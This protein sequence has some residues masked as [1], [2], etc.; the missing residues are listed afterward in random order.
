MDLW[1]TKESERSVAGV[2]AAFAFLLPWDITYIGDIA[3][4]SLVYFRFP[5]WEFQWSPGIQ[6]VEETTFRF[7]NEAWDLRRGA[8]LEPAY[9][10]YLV[11]AAF[12]VLGVLLAIGLFVSEPRE[13]GINPTRVVGGLLAFAGLSFLIGWWFLVTRGASGI[14]IPL[15]AT[16]TTA[17]GVVLVLAD[18]QD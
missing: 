11:G 10:A 16:L 7:L 1:I 5:L 13:G 9:D 8:P 6:G 3:G 12:I 14:D 18:R 15:G 17:L 2:A 4:G